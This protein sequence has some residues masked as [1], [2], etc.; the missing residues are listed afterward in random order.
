MNPLFLVSFFAYISILITIGYII[1]KKQKSS[2]EFI[3]GNR[4]INYWVT[5]I[6]T[7]ATDMSTWLFM[8]FPAYVF[9]G[10]IFECWNAIGLI[11]F[12]YLS[13]Q[14]IAK[15]L[16]IST[17]KYNCETL[18]SYFEQ[19]FND[20]T[21]TIR[22]VSTVVALFF[23]TLYISA[24][25]VGLGRA[26]SATF[27]FSYLTGITFGTLTVALYTVL[28]GFVAVAWN[29]FL[30]G[31]FVL[32]VIVGVPIYALFSFGGFSSITIAAQTK[33]I[34]LSLF[35]DFSAKT[36][37]AIFV[38]AFGWGLGYFGQPHILIN[39]MGIKNPQN[40]NKA[41]RIG[42]AWQIIAM[43]CAT[44]IGLIGIAFFKTGLPNNELVFINLVKNISTPLFA[45][46]ILC[47]ILAAAISTMDSQIL[48]SASML[49]ED[50]YKKVFNKK[51]SSK[52]QLH[53]S[54]I[55]GI[56]ITII[57]FVMAINNNETIWKLVQYAWHGLGSSFGPLV[58]LS[59]YSKTVN[60]FGALAGIIS[61]SAIT[62]IW[63]HLPTSIPDAPIIPGF[64]ISFLS[65]VVVSWLTRRLDRSHFPLG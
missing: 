24:G 64:I 52:K 6:A 7:H 60:K 13:W 3:V 16:R 14:F 53:V 11:V 39:F 48:V 28:G 25:I 37:F 36:F 32:I 31:L 1:Y 15:K 65:I 34:S 29:D 10:G 50:I 5:A 58:I 4:S 55:A 38:A 26:L 57:S 41:K 27:E 42:I 49:S 43:T 2:T 30:Q 44:L 22:I 18:S 46:F 20:K 8:A 54:R 62:L 35:P 61:G 9:S 19:R 33:G 45:G 59:L 56:G 12:M 23:F 40:I 51:I 21:G 47:A 63:K 17:E